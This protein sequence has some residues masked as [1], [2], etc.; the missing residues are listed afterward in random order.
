MARG[1]RQLAIVVFAATGTFAVGR[2]FGT[3][4]A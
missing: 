2:I 4:V 1:L 3:A